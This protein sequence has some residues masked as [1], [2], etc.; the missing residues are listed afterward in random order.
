[1]IVC[2]VFKHGESLRLLIHDTLIL[3]PFS[4]PLNQGWV[5]PSIPVETR[6]ELN[7]GDLAAEEIAFL[8]AGEIVHLH[9]THRVV[10]DFAAVS[11]QRGAVAMRVPVRPDEVRISP[12]RLWNTT[13]TAELLARATLHPFYGI[14][15]SIFTSSDSPDAQVVV[16]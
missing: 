7:A 12:I 15:P 8:P 9:D 11:F 3:S 5:K 2:R 4:I 14:T 1:M 16:V 6:A 13:T 10:P